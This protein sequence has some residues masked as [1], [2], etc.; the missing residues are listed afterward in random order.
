M[1]SQAKPDT[2]TISF[3]GISVQPKTLTALTALVVDTIE[4]QEKCVIANHNLHSLYLFHHEPKFRAFYRDAACT[5]I[6]GMP[7][8]ALARLYGHRVNREHRVTYVDWTGWLMEAAVREQWRV[9]YL[10]SAPGIAEA[11]AS[12]LRERFPGLQIQTAHGYFDADPQSQDNAR[13]LSAIAQFA[14]H[15]LMV[16]MGMP[17]Q[18]YWIHENFARLC[19]NVIL[20]SG[21][22]MDY[23]AG[24]AYIPPRWSGRVGLEWVFRLAA[25]PKRLWRR[26]LLEPWSVVGIV[27][28]D[29]IKNLVSTSSVREMG[30]SSLPQQSDLPDAGRGGALQEQG[31][32]WVDSGQPGADDP[33]V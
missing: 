31:A 28:R 25:E 1:T 4:Q 30:W 21:A 7:I 22:A 5:H 12:L 8:V 11:G 18:E 13:V 2:D 27:V 19:A 6:D 9:F 3:L 26:Y 10:G 24:A 15:M 29:L 32:K 20:P 23:V 16:G 17:R 14:P 33:S